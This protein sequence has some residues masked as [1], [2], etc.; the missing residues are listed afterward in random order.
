MRQAK[1][2]GFDDLQRDYAA[3]KARWGGFAGYDRIVGTEPNNALLASITAYSKLV[4]GFEKLLG[5]AGGNLPRFYAEVRRVAALPLKERC[6]GLSIK[7]ATEVAVDA[8]AVPVLN[9]K[10]RAPANS[11]A[12]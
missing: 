1:R 12:C 7:P 4:P 10:T 11:E 8:A 5:E 6:A 3:L 9:P 2:A